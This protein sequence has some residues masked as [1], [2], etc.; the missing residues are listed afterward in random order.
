MRKSFPNFGQ[1]LPLVGMGG[2]ERASD[3]FLTGGT[4]DTITE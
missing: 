1:G 4:R 3:G 2:A